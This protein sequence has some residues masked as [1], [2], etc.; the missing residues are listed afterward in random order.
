MHNGTDDAGDSSEALVLAS[1]SLCPLG[2]LEKGY[3]S[4]SGCSSPVL[5]ANFGDFGPYP[6]AGRFDRITACVGNHPPEMIA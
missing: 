5:G 2:E 1:R 3:V 6:R 4:V